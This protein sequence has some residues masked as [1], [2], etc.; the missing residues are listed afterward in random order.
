MSSSS[1]KASVV[2]PV[3]VV[4]QRVNRAELKAVGLIARGLVVFVSFN[5]SLGEDAKAAATA[6]E[7]AARAILTVPLL[8]MGRWGDGSKPEGF[9][10]LVARRGD[11]GLG[12]S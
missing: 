2:G 8:S 9:L 4:A 7:K 12:E 5:A 1:S 10:K 3:R 11:E 6:C